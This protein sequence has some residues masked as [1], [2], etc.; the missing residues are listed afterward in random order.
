MEPDIGKE[1]CGGGCGGKGW[2]VK[3][4]FPTT[5]CSPALTVSRLTF[6]HGVVLEFSFIANI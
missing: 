4:R 1:R 3:A 6:D 2:I 5:H